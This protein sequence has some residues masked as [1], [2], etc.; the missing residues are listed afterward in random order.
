ML[1]STFATLVRC[2]SWHPDI[3]LR[4]AGCRGSGSF[5]RPGVICLMEL[6]LHISLLWLQAITPAVTSCGHYPASSL[7][8]LYWSRKPC[9]PSFIRQPTNSSGSGSV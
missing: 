2:P 3:L 8:V 7:P 1:Q 4:L 5:R 6:V 9:F